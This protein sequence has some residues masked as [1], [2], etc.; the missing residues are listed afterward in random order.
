MGNGRPFHFHAEPLEIL[1]N[2]LLD[3]F[4][5]DKLVPAYNPAPVHRYVRVGFL[6]A[7]YRKLGQ[8]A[9][10]W[11][12][13]PPELGH[14]PQRVAKYLHIHVMV[15]DICGYH[16][17]PDINFIFQGACN[18]RIDN[19][20]HLE[21]VAEDL[22]TDCRIYLANP[23]PYDNCFCAV[24]RPFPKF[25][26]SLFHFAAEF[27]FPFQGFHFQFHGSDNP[28]FFHFMSLSLVFQCFIPA[29]NEPSS[30][31]CADIWRMPRGSNAL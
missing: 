24:Q 6:T 5:A 8:M 2:P 12:G 4:V 13:Q 30:R 9:V 19:M 11:E 28:Y 15:E 26:G 20:G 10:C 22:G 25:H 14:F 17:V 1:N 29:S 21:T 31:A 27:H 16:N 3:C 18:A 23:A 7:V